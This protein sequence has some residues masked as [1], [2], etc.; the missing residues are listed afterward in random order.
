MR[1]ALVVVVLVVLGFGAGVALWAISGFVLFLVGFSFYSVYGGLF[2][3][4]AVFLVVAPIVYVRMRKRASPSLRHVTPFLTGMVVF[5]VYGCV[6]VALR[7]PYS[8]IGP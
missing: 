3:A 5:L 6:S 2:F 7:V 8:S 4:L 1:R